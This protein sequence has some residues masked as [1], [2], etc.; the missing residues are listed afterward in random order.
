M[1]A[2]ETEDDADFSLDLLDGASD[3]DTSDTLNVSNLTLDSGDDAGITIN[4]NNLDISP[5][6]YNSLAA[7]ESEVIEYSYDIIDGN[8]GVVAQTATITINGVNDA[9]TANDDGNVGFTTNEDTNFTTVNVLDNDTDPDT[10]DTLSVLSIDTT[11]T[12]GTVTNNGDGTFGYA[13]NGQFETLAVGE[14]A[15]DTFTSVSYTHLTLP[16][17]YSV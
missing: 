1:T 8:G 2:T 17:I 12:Q 11:G 9:P 7:G 16:T 3:I 15:T 5:S 13:P 14:T 10:S 6:A 4:G